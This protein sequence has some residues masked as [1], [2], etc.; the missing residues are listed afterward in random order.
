MHRFW[1]ALMKFELLS[2]AMT[3]QLLTPYI[4][5]DNHFDRFYG[6]G[7][8]IDTK[9]DNIFKYHVMGYD[10]GVSF[11]SAYYPESGMVSVVC[12]NKSEGAFDVFKEIE[13]R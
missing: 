7:V 10:P 9:E 3:K 13:K 1:Q 12:S 5:T 4:H 6:Y 2:E 11:H 8:W